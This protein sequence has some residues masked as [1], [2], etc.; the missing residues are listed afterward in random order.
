[1]CG[2]KKALGAT[3][4]MFKLQM[5]ETSNPK[6]GCGEKRHAS[7]HCHLVGMLTDDAPDPLLSSSSSYFQTPTDLPTPTLKTGEN[8]RNTQPDYS[9]YAIIEYVTNTLRIALVNQIKK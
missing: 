1:M 5:R 4:L 2:G 3:A 7:V 6:H 8:H 9:R